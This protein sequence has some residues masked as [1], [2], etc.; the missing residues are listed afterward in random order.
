MVKKRFCFTIDDN[1]RFLHEL[2]AKK[3]PS[4]F[5]HP[6]MQALKSLHEKYGVK[7]Q[8]NLFYKTKDFALE[9]MDSSYYQEWQKNADWLKLSFHSKEENERPYQNAGYSEVYDDCQAVQKQIIRFAGGNSLAKTTTVH[10]C[11]T[12]HEGLCALKDNGVKGLLGLYG[13][14]EN[15]RVSY[16]CSKEQG[17]KLRLGLIETYDG[18]AFLNIF[19]VL[20]RLTVDEIAKK[21]NNLQTEN[22]SIMI[23]EQYF[24]PDYIAYQKDFVKKLETAF[25]L[26]IKQGYQSSF[27]EEMIV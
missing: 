12:T 8:L 16:A 15:P 13:T 17:D 23:H 9:D 6:Y 7:M 24:Y 20:N 3:M 11:V 18:L 14:Q 19:A 25:S 2:T 27:F 5:S 10:Y 1:I 26:L 22:I 4:L 21:L